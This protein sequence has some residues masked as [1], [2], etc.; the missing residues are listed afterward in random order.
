M[1]G[2]R[3]RRILRSNVDFLA[4]RGLSGFAQDLKDR[5][6]S[7][8]LC[9]V[10]CLDRPPGTPSKARDHLQR[11]HFLLP[12]ELAVAH[13][14]PLPREVVPQPASVVCL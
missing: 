13:P 2:G 7:V 9:C 3:G 1:V 6:S 14:L 4:H 12:P 8:G 10:R 11:N 5:V